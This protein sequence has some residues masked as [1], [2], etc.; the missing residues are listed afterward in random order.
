M[1]KGSK[2]VQTRRALVIAAHPDDAEFGCSGTA[3][4]WSR[5]GWEFYY[6]ILTD[7]SKGSEDPDMTAA[8]LTSVRRKEQQAAADVLGIKEVTFLNFVDG[9]LTYNPQVMREVVRQ[10][11]R[12]RPYA[13]FSSDPNQIVHNSYI[14]HPDHRAA[15]MISLDAVYPIAR[16]R[17]SFPELLED[18]LEPHSTREVYLWSADQPNFQVDVSS[19]IDLKLEALIQHKSQFVGMEEKVE[20][21]RERWVEDSGGYFERFRRIELSF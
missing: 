16:N 2:Q 13:V 12:I 17:P 10:I 14:N 7:G 19:A 1:D 11:R 6:L 20:S 9:E 5:D 15:G 21:W 18:G 4:L 3:A 8:R